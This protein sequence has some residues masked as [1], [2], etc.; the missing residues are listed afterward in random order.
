MMSMALKV[1]SVDINKHAL[2]NAVREPDEARIVRAL[3]SITQRPPSIKWAAEGCV[4]A[5]MC[6][7]FSLKARFDNVH[8]VEHGVVSAEEPRFRPDSTSRPPNRVF[9]GSRKPFVAIR[10]TIGRSDRAAS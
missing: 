9:C 2:E 3:P 4:Q 7:L 8:W 5:S 1:V 6:S 10:P